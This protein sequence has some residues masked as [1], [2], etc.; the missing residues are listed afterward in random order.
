M[1]DLTL[2][3]EN[4]TLFYV[5]AE[6]EVY[7]AKWYGIDVVIKRRIPK[8]YRI[9]ELDEEIRFRRTMREAK[10]LHYAKKAGVPTPT[11]YFLDPTNSTIIMNFIEGE[12]TREALSKFTGEE[13]V[14][15]I[16]LI[17]VYTGR[18]HQA[19]IQHGDLTTSNM[20]LTEDGRI[21]IVDFG[22]G[23]FTNEVEDMAVDLILFRRALMSTHYMFAEECFKAFLRGYASIRGRK[24]AD[25]VLDKA[26]EVEKRG[27]YVIRS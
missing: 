3:F 26:R 22:L 8:P 27:R 19:G 6:A 18:L 10:I 15:K 9:K 1:V 14:R 17:G 4:P 23:A 2:R 13:R 7:R 21:F 25:K 20:I 12:R 11:V 5:G 16:E 24:I